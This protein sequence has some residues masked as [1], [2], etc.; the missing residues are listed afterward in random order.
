MFLQ[1]MVAPILKETL[2]IK[3]QTIMLLVSFARNQFRIAIAFENDRRHFELKKVS[4][5]AI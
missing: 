2:S 3:S 5:V 1:E 4:L